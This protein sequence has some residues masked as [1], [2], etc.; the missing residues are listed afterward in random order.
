MIFRI[1]PIKIGEFEVDLGLDGIMLLCF[2]DDKPGVIGRIGAILGESK[3][4]IGYMQ[5]GRLKAGK[6]AIT[7]LS[8]DSEAPQIVLDK[9]RNIPEMKDVKIVKI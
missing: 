8:I 2:N 4:N 7:L 1:I 3:I 9:L 5:V 6:E